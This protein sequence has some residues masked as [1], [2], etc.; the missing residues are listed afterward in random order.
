MSPASFQSLRA[1]NML[2]SLCLSQNSSSE[3]RARMSVAQTALS[4]VSP[5]VYEFIGGRPS[6]HGVPALAGSATEGM[7]AGL[8]R[9][10]GRLKPGLRAY[11]GAGALNT[12]PTASRRTLRPATRVPFTLIDH[13]LATRDTAGWGSLRYGRC[14]AG[15]ILRL[16]WV[17]V[18]A[19]S[20][21]AAGAACGTPGAEHE[22]RRPG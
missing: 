2:R 11:N 15:G 1:L 22:R 9:T 16:N 19:T 4:E 17:T 7:R 10:R 20:A 14:R 6:P 21:L 13:G 5:T 18:S 8:S 3:R 12:Y